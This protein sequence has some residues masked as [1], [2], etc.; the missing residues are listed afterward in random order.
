VGCCGAVTDSSRSRVVAC[1]RGRGVPPCQTFCRSPVC[2]AAAP[3]GDMHRCGVVDGDV[4]CAT[5]RISRAS[6]G[7]C[8]RRLG[9]LTGGDTSGQ[10]WAGLSSAGSH[11]HR[12][13]SCDVV[14]QAVAAQRL[15]A[16]RCPTRYVF[17]TDYA[18]SILVARSPRRSGV[19]WATCLSERALQPLKATGL[20]TDYAGL[21]LVGRS[22]EDPSTLLGHT[23]L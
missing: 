4:V 9:L 13:T 18:S 12:M 1:I 5:G 11:V 7:P 17:Q 23:P 6:I 14:V 10:E 3:V 15:R 16:S 22:V 19:C 2:G 8:P 21:V 20:E